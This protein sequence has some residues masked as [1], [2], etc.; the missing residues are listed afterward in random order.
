MTLDWN[1]VEGAAFY[2]VR[3]WKATE[4]VELPTGDIGIVLNGSGATARKPD[5][6]FYYRCGPA[7]RRVCR[8]GRSSSPWPTLLVHQLGR[9]GRWSDAGSGRRT[10]PADGRWLAA[11]GG[12]SPPCQVHRSRVTA[13]FDVVITSLPC[14]LPLHRFSQARPAGTR[15]RDTGQRGVG[16]AGCDG[17][18]R[19]C[20]R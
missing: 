15:A 16:H 2:Q 4:W 6:G 17:V 20:P 8:T 5:Y 10:S 14:Q 12:Q 3:F 7:T 11:R 13:E 18:G 19:M 1:D 9:T